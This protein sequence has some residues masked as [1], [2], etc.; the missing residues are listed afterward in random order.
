[1]ANRIAIA[2]QK[3]GV[4]KTTTAVNLAASLAAADCRVLLIDCDP[5]GNASSGVGIRPDPGSASIY[6][7]LI[8]GCPYAD[9]V[10]RTSFSGL[11][12]IPSSRDLAGANVE[13]ATHDG[14]AELLKQHLRG[15]GESY[16]FILLDC[17]PALDLITLNALA[18]ADSVLIPMH[19]EYYAL[20][21][22]SSLVRTMDSVRAGLNPGLALE[23]VL[24]TMYDGRL[25]LTQQVAEEVREH[26]GPSVL[27]TVIPRNVRL[28]EAPSHG[29]P[30]LQYD[31][32]STGAE[33]Y[34]NLAREIL[35]RAR[36]GRAKSRAESEG[37]D[38]SNTT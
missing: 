4:G 36:S 5:Q 2:N 25:S 10:R 24:L 1:M 19:C 34:L 33:S 7:V 3:G 32:R 18:A 31:A 12:L 13:L 20:E 38:A 22:I 8:G 26:F 37:P 17:P 11:H 14:P 21:G 28:A 35:A 23:G 30:A 27:N 16:D 29:M 9:A 15:A 6:D